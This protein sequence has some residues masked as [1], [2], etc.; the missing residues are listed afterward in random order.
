[1]FEFFFLPP[2]QPLSNSFS[3]YL[4]SAS[5]RNIASSTLIEDN[6]SNHNQ[7]PIPNALPHIN[8]QDGLYDRPFDR[9]TPI[10]RSLHPQP[11][12]QQQPQSTTGPKRACSALTTNDIKISSA[13]IPATISDPTPLSEYRQQDRATAEDDN[14]SDM[15]DKISNPFAIKHDTPAINFNAHLQKSK[16]LFSNK[17]YLSSSRSLSNYR[18]RRQPS[19]SSSLYRSTSSLN[20]NNSTTSTQS[21]FASPFYNGQTT[22]GGASSQSKRLR[23]A[24]QP[25][26]Q[27]QYQH[28]SHVPSKLIPS[29]L[30]KSTS[31]LNSVDSGTSCLSTTAKRILDLMNQ[32]NTP[33]ADVRQVSSSLASSTAGSRR[34]PNPSSS[35]LDIDN[36]NESILDRSRRKLLK[37]NTPYHRPHGRNA[38]YSF[39][40]ELKVPSMSQLLQLK[41][42]TI[43]MREIASNSKSVLNRREEYK[44]PATADTDA[45]KNSITNNNNNIE[46]QTKHVNKIRNNLTKKIVKT[47]KNADDDAPPEVVNLPNIQLPIKKDVAITFSGASFTIPASVNSTAVATLSTASPSITPSFSQSSQSMTIAADSTNPFGSFKTTTPQ[48]SNATKDE[49]K[50][51]SSK[52][53]DVHKP[54]TPNAKFSFG[55]LSSPNTNTTASKPLPVSSNSLA[56]VP[57]FAFGNS[58]ENKT[59]TNTLA[60]PI[61]NAGSK[62]TSTSINYKFSQPIFVQQSNACDQLATSRTFAKQVYKFSEP[63]YVDVKATTDA[64]PNAEKKV[65]SIMG[66]HN[67]KATPSSSPSTNSKSTASFSFGTLNKT[68]TPIA[69]QSTLSSTGF[70]FGKSTF[71]GSSPLSSSESA[72]SPIAQSKSDAFNKPAVNPSFTFNTSNMDKKDT[73]EVAKDDRESTATVD[74]IFKSIAAKQKEGKWTCDGCMERNDISRTTCLVCETPKPGSTAKTTA[75]PVAAGPAATSSSITA[76]NTVDDVFKSLAAQ[77]KSSKWRCPTCDV[78]NDKTALTCLCCNEPQP[79]ASASDSAAATISKPPQSQFSF[80]TLGNNAFSAKPSTQFSFGSGN[81]TTSTAS[82]TNQSFSFG[83]KPSGEL[84]TTSSTTAATTSQ[85]SFGS[86]AAKEPAKATA[87]QHSFG[88]QPIEAAKPSSQFSIGSPANQFSFGSPASSSVPSEKPQPATSQFTFGS[89][90]AAVPAEQAPVIAAPAA[91]IDDVFKKIVQQQAAQWECGSC[92]SKNDSAKDKCVCCEQP[93][94]GSISAAKPSDLGGQNKFQFG[95]SST[96]FSFGVQPSAGAKDS[97]IATAVASFSTS[98]APSSSTNSFTFGGFP[99]KTGSFTFGS[100]SPKTATPNAFGS[101][102]T[103]TVDASKPTSTSGGF[104]FGSS[105]AGKRTANASEDV[106]DTAAGSSS[107]AEGIKVLENIVVK[108]ASVGN[109]PAEKRSSFAFGSSSTNEN[110]VKSNSSPFGS[111]PIAAT[112]G[113]NFFKQTTTSASAMPNATFVFGQSNVNSEG[114]KAAAEATSAGAVEPKSTFTFGSVTSSN[115]NSNMSGMAQF[116]SL[117]PTTIPAVMPA[118]GKISFPTGGSSSATTNQTMAGAPPEFKSNQPMAQFASLKPTTIPAVMPVFGQISFPTGG[119]S[120]GDGGGGALSEKAFK[121]SPFTFGSGATNA[122]ATTFGNPAPNTNSA[123]VSDS[124]LEGRQTVARADFHSGYSWYFSGARYFPI[125]QRHNQQ[126]TH[127]NKR[128]ILIFNWCR[129]QFQF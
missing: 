3:T 113:T 14:S 57:K 82:A 65:S 95:A 91:P 72:A 74:D 111:S 108:P 48:P 38:E 88:S 84:K 121:P 2:A 81:T 49:K 63:I 124:E 69:V 129:T 94:D 86:H 71:S 62:L 37:P 46:P 13:T 8:G 64:T 110:D 123:E 10:Q 61:T 50:A 70:E 31:S 43:E 45:S 83:S 118:F 35:I 67:F 115:N 75:A 117:K 20:D 99:P 42:N 93:K 54:P 126:Y 29:H 53:I 28:R 26:P 98:N 107:S 122:A 22:F 103:G 34:Q 120:G 66:I 85:F 128:G 109:G 114:M 51:E 90:P 116:A 55:T 97:T 100:F 87:T 7:T 92:L 24:F 102:S 76:A 105:A 39:T 47:R 25:D 30:S 5:H 1:M 77:Q 17:S 15:Q 127:T 36:S 19:Y 21:A 68:A 16:S 6:R 104:Q 96:K 33:L 9:L 58:I 59:D 106:A 60:T 23:G 56:T 80:G 112:A 78:S 4:Q 32:Y 73:S 89:S 125:W 119:S 52:A 11:Q 18:L 79:G 44:L 40:S 12:Q 41:R 27:L 101:S